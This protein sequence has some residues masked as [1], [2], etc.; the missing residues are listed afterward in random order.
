[1]DVCAYVSTEFKDTGNKTVKHKFDAFHQG[2][3]NFV[4]LPWFSNSKIDMMLIVSRVN[5]KAA[6]RIPNLTSSFDAH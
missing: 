1:M 5:L 3:F 2:N 4:I 6:I